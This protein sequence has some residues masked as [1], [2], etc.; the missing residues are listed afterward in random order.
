MYLLDVSFNV[1]FHVTFDDPCCKQ[2]PKVRI[3]VLTH[4]LY[5]YE[6]RVAFSVESVFLLNQ[7]AR[8]VKQKVWSEACEAFAFRRR[9]ALSLLLR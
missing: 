2:T 1:Q 3:S 4:I 6:L 9:N 8:T 7:D 5:M